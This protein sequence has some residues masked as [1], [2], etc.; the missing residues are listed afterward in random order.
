MVF[1]SEH[2]RIDA[3]SVVRLRYFVKVPYRAQA[4]LTRRA[5]FAR[6]HW[7]CQYCGKAA[8]NVD[9]VIPRSKGGPHT[10]DNVVAA[11]RRCNSKKE[12]KKPHEAGLKLARRPFVP[13]DGFRLSLGR[14]E[15]AWEPFL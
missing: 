2:L 9:H 10:W 13:S 8:E 1:R 5:V 4:A 14:L 12:N 15:P 6:D 7:V 3:P 11:C